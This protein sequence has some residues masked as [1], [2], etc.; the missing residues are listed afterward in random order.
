MKQ[1]A[2][3]FPFS[4]TA[5]T[6]LLVVVGVLLIFNIRLIFFGAGPRQCFVA[7]TQQLSSAPS[8]LQLGG[9]RDAWQV[10]D[11]ASTAPDV[12]LHVG[13]G[14]RSTCSPD[15]GA[16]DCFPGVR[17]AKPAARRAIATFV[18]DD[19]SLA[20]ALTL[21]YTLR[22]HGNALPLIL[23]TINGPKHLSPVSRSVLTCAGWHI[24]EWQ[25]I[26]PFKPVSKESQ[27]G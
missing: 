18:A 7:P 1:A 11:N 16:F 17:T 12:C 26:K 5:P 4:F 27:D 14:S 21:A 22:K 10:H 6:V 20:A 15:N 24:R 23:F 13:T 8:H 25:E 2:S 9:D 3:P 19:D